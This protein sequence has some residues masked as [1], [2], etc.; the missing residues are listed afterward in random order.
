MQ[1]KIAFFVF[2]RDLGPFIHVM[3]YAKEILSSGNKVEIVLEDRATALLYEL[4][5]PSRLSAALFDE[6]VRDNIIVICRACAVKTES[7]VIA[8]EKKIT[9]VG[10]LEGHVSVLTYLK[11][12]FTIITV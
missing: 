7:I 11:K 10:D 5:D 6:L 8:E 1:D 9:V 4:A 3:K 2:R 12:G